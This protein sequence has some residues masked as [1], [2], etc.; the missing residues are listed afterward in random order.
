M[1]VFW[2][3]FL[4]LISSAIAASLQNGDIHSKD[5]MIAYI[6]SIKLAPPKFKPHPSNPSLIRDLPPDNKKQGYIVGG[7]LT[8][9][10]ENV[11][12]QD[13]QDI[14][15]ATL[16]AQR[17]AD[18]LYN[19]ENDTEKWYKYY[20]DVLGN[21]GFTLEGFSFQKYQA[22]GDSFI[23]SEVVLEILA[24]VATEGQS[25]VI[26]ATLDVMRDLN[27][28]DKRIELFELQSTNLH[29][30][31]F[32]IYPCDQASTGEVSLALGGF[33]FNTAVDRANFLFF[34][35]GTSDSYIYEGA[36]KAILNSQVYSKVR[37]TVS[38]KLGDTALELVAAIDI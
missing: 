4:A 27:N 23:M 6:N 2:V 24:A 8:A 1:K 16:F 37:S 31:N 26:Q 11:K 28:E 19:R 35:F 13:K 14:L 29:T 36:Q 5:E 30:G 7:G 12:G 33:Y 34:S 25:T 17:A 15:D 21:V 32:Q 18:S 10:T 22:K 3:A 38:S 20:I 9:F